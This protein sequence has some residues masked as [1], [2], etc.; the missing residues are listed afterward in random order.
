MATRCGTVRPHCPKVNRRTDIFVTLEYV[1][2]QVW[3]DRCRVH[4]LRALQENARS[5][6]GS[7][8]KMLFNGKERDSFGM[9]GKQKGKVER[10][11]DESWPYAG[12]N[13]K[14]NKENLGVT[15][16]KWRLTTRYRQLG[17]GAERENLSRMCVAFRDLHKSLSKEV[18]S[19]FSASIV[20]RIRCAVWKAFVFEHF[21]CF[22]FYP[23]H[24][25]PG[26]GL[27]R[28]PEDV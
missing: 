12:R 11:D 7:K 21:L 22:L 15:L 28:T 14:K 20:E 19:L 5:R 25:I 24:P 2:R 26:L 4:V 1:G 8:N 10:R 23:W 3:S 18:I 9:R 6:R 27:R 13:E 16:K 17:L